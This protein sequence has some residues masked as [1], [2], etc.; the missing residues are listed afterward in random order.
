[1]TQNSVVNADKTK[2]PLYS[3]CIKKTVHKGTSSTEKSF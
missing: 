1:M 2:C 3:K